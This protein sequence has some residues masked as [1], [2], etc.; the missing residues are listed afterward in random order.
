MT[1]ACALSGER[2]VRALRNPDDCAEPE[3]R[4]SQLADQTRTPV[5]F[6]NGLRVADTAVRCGYIE[7]M[8]GG[9]KTRAAQDSDAPGLIALIGSAYAE[10]P[11][12]VLDVEGEEPDLL[13]IASAYARKG[14]GFWVTIDPIS[15]AL[16]ACVGWAPSRAPALG[17]VEL[18][19]LYVARAYRRRGLASECCARVEQVARARS[20][21]GIELWSDSRFVEAHH[22]YAARGF[23]RQSETRE[24][25][26]L[27]HT[28]E[29]RFTKKFLA[30]AGA[31]ASG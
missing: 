4:V 30:S 15:A 11:G 21:A 20:A 8:L 2:Q 24:L 17:W 1:S 26:D 14:G 3:S 10:Y 12:C 19:K 5:A 23:E 18:R 7:R 31:E 29:Y 22:F 6:C 27:S 9:L 28:T 25:F 13:A 16:V